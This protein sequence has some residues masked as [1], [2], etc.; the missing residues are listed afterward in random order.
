MHGWIF[1]TCTVQDDSEL[2]ERAGLAEPV[3]SRTRI[4]EL[5]SG[6]VG[7]E[8]VFHCDFALCHA[9]TVALTGLLRG[10]FPSDTALAGRAAVESQPRFADSA[11]PFARY[12]GRGVRQIP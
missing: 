3:T 4:G 5:L 6:R 9:S 1:G 10:R 11:G 2:I 8:L 7:R 12:T